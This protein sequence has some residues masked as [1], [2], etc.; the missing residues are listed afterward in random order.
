MHGFIVDE[1]ESPRKELNAGLNSKA[2][3]EREP[4]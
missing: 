1:K 3:F 4:G 2:R